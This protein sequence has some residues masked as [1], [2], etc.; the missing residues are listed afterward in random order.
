MGSEVGPNSSLGT[1]RKSDVLSLPQVGMIRDDERPL[2]FAKTSE[3]D[4][5]TENQNQLP[6]IVESAPEGVFDRLK[7][8]VEDLGIRVGKFFLS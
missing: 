4:G 7:K 3:S 1:K 5:E 8:V 6:A 2:K